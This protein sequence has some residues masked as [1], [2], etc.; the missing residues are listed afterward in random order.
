MQCGKPKADH[1][2]LGEVRSFATGATRDSD[3]GK[4]D[5][6]AFLSPLVLRAYGHH[7]EK[8]R[9]QSDGNK[10]SADNWQKGIPMDQYM[11]SMWRHFL[12]VWSIWRGWSSKDSLEGALCALLFNVMGMLHEHLKQKYE[13]TTNGR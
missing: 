11:K 2:G 5:Y 6:E 1:V 3:E 7:M 4:R 8:H 12:D 10:R 13:G 9:T